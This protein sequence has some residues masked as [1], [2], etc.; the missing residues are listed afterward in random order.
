M[1]VRNLKGEVVDLPDQEPAAADDGGRLTR[2][3]RRL[4]EAEYLLDSTVTHVR[5]KGCDDIKPRSLARIQKAVNAL[6]GGIVMVRLE[7]GVRHPTLFA[8]SAN[9]EGPGRVQRQKSW[10]SHVA[11]GWARDC[12]EEEEVEDGMVDEELGR[13]L[14]AECWFCDAVFVKEEWH[15]ACGLWRCP[16]CGKCGC[17]LGDFTRT[18]V[19]KTYR[20]LSARGR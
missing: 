15:E 9:P 16:D 12:V 6:R 19:E 7:A 17:D 1:R 18:A 20:A 10:G 5:R 14:E 4:V 3:E 13:G 8:G 11:H 2:I